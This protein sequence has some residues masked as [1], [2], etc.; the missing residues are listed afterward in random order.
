[1]ARELGQ[2]FGV[3]DGWQP[4]W[5]VDLPPR[6]GGQF[7]NVAANVVTGGVESVGLA[8]Q[9]EPAPWP[10]VVAGPGDPLPVAAV[11]GDVSVDQQ[12]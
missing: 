2:R 11:A 12:T 9:V 3:A 4:P 8:E 1:M 7:R 6:G 5:L 10:G